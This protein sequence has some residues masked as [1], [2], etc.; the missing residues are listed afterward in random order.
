M[1][2]KS[3]GGMRQ[4]RPV[5][6]WVDLNILHGGD[7]KTMPKRSDKNLELRSPLNQI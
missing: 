7:S 3:S 2:I 5:W 4:T 1:L 6:E